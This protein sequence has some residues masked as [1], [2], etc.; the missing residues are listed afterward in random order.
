MIY[1]ASPYTHSDPVIMD[2]R[3]RT[4]RDFTAHMMRKNFIA[5]SPIVYGHEMAKEHDLPTDYE[6][7]KRFNDYMMRCSVAM[8]VLRLEGWEESRGVAYELDF[9]KELNRSVFHYDP[10]TYDLVGFEER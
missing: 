3:Y 4:V 6:Y 8:C 5:F 10:A 2:Y 7:W 1:I 9:A